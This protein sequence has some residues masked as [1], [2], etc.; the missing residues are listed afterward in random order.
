MQFSM[1]EPGEKELSKTEPP[2][3]IKNKVLMGP[4]TWNETDYTTSEIS[5]AYLN[6]DWQ[7]KD[8]LSI[9]LDHKD[10]ESSDWVGWIKNPRMNGDKLIGDLELWD[11]DIATKLIK[12][13]A[14]FGISP[15]LKGNEMGDSLKDF[16][17]ENFSIVTK[18]AVK[19]AY[20]NL[21]KKE[22]GQMKKLLEEEQPK[23]GE[24]SEEPKEEIKEETK[25][26]A[27]KKYPYPEEDKE[28]LRK[29]KKWLRNQFINVWNVEKFLLQ[30]KAVPLANLQISKLFLRQKKQ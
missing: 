9:F 13:K 27:K 2:F 12:A 7:D 3:T 28:K 15:K 20:I 5:K 17:F 8:V 14:K 26:L 18:P 22:G 16:I 6:T 19:T 11:E 29:K 23:E 21:I 24:G 4:G 25:E 30:K 10:R 1:L